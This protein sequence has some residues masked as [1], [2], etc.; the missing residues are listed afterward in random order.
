M[1][2]EFGEIVLVVRE[3]GVRCK[4][5]SLRNMHH[6]VRFHNLQQIRR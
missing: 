4:S 2:L 6:A 3:R 5:A 1:D